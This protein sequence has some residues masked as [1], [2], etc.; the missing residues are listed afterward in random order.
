MKPDLS[1]RIE[2]EKMV[3]SF[4][5]KVKEDETIGYFFNVVMKVDWNEHLPKMY[6]FW[7][8]IILG[9]SKYSGNPVQKHVH[10]NSL[11]KMEKKHFDRWLEL[12]Y[13][14]LEE[15]FE[16]SNTELARQRALSIAT[17]MEIKINTN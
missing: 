14:N 12:F 16:G 13:Q 15:H 11:S 5:D 8:G 1:S 3:N 4:Y 2:I 17:V 9:G 10:I 6:D 7:E